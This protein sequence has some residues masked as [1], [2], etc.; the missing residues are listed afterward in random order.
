MLDLDLYD[1][2][3]AC[4]WTVGSF[5]LL[6]R[7]ALDDVGAMDERFFLY[8]EETDLCLRTH[9]A[10]WEVV[11]LPQMTILHQSSTTGSDERLS[12]ADGVRPTAVHDEALLDRPQDRRDARTRPRVCPSFGQARPRFG[13]LAGA[14]PPL[15]SALATL[16]GLAPPPF[17]DPST[18]ST[19][20][21]AA[22][23]GGP[24]AS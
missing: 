6:R 11:H 12:R 17:G 21:T 8:C 15:R 1:R 14:A 3:T 7:T 23:A 5:M 2:E 24:P 19:T 9:E 18:G 20:K 10:G 4:D 22:V 16:L 13:R